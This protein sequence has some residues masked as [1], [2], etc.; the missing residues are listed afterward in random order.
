MAA[1]NFTTLYQYKIEFSWK[2][3]KNAERES[4]FGQD[5][6]WGLVTESVSFSM[7]I[8]T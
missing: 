7:L 3:P 6:L 5:M 8:S 4:L 1:Y 2:F